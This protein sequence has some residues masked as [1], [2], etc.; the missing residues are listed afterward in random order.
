M[1]S[2]VA[3][4]LVLFLEYDLFDNFVHHEHVHLSD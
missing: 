3:Q 4:L 2:M 1:A